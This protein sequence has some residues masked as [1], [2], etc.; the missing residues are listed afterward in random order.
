MVG[1]GKGAENG[2]LFKNSEA[3]EQAH[4]LKVIVLDKTG[5]ITVGQPAVTDVVANGESAEAELLRLAA[6][7]ERG[8][9]HPLGEAIVQ[10]ARARGLALAEPE[11][12]EALSGRGIVANEWAASCFSRANPTPFAGRLNAAFIGIMTNIHDSIRAMPH[13]EAKANMVERF[14]GQNSLFGP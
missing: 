7:A 10:E 5:T 13:L 2:I 11:A 12:F 1:T 3:L 4:S 9:E 8:S 14:I 6:S